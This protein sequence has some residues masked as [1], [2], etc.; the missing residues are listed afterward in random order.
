MITRRHFIK[1]NGVTTAGLGL[2]LRPT[3][4]KGNPALF[5]SNRP[6]LAD[7]KFISNAIE[8]KIKSIKAAI[9]DPELAWLF[10]N[11]YPNTLDTTVNYS[12]IN[13]KPDTFVITG[14]I[15]AMW[16]RDSSAQVWPYMPLINKDA[17]LK[18]LLLGVINRQAKCILIDPY[19]NAFNF[20]PTGSEWDKDD[21]TMKPELHERKW[22]I[23]SL[24][25]PVRLAYN[26]WKTSSDISFF[27]EEWQQ[28]AK[29]I[30]Q[31]FKQQQRKHDSGPYHFQRLTEVASDTAP[32][33]G[34]GN[35]IK[36]VGLICSIF[37]PSDDSTIFPFLV[38]SN[39]FAVVSLNQLAEMFSTIGKDDSTAA[40]YRGLATEVHTALQKYATSEHPVFG[41]VLAY[42]VDGFGNQL[43]MDDANVPSLLALPYLDAISAHDPIYQNTRRMVLSQTN[44]YFFKGKAAEGIG[45]PHVGMNC[46]W[47]MSIIIRAITST[48]KNEIAACLNWLKTT[49]A[50]TGFMHESFNKD[51]PADFTRKWFAWANTLFGELVIKTHQYYPELLN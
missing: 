15:N 42:E 7:R 18:K 36:P 17:A 45:G 11:C 28:A 37:R 21:T 13:G 41:K 44:P 2:G 24:C 43:F 3:W 4:F 35:P 39:Y 25:Y 1:L 20:G 50:H 48:N 8:E 51:N 14:D 33:G 12:E 5:I 47:P 22:E 34:Y 9:K 23:D 46:I 30:L 27:D 10:E 19:A 40:E 26:Y 6:K 31:T 29:L 32:S 49:H 16:M 38:P